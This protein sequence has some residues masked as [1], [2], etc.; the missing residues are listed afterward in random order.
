MT[1][2]AYMFPQVVSILMVFPTQ[3]TRYR[4]CMVFYN[5]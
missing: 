3:A 2:H 1:V 5:R 4:H